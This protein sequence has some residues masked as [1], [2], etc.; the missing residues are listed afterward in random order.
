MHNNGNIN[1]FIFRF[2]YV[3]E[4][5]FNVLERFG[6]MLRLGYNSEQDKD[7]IGTDIWYALVSKGT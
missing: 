5:S 4:K 2:R 6:Q 7:K 1:A 3:N